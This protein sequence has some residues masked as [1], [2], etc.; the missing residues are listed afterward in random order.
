MSK[1]DNEFG[2]YVH[3]GVGYAGTSKDNARRIHPRV[4]HLGVG[5]GGIYD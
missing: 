3:Y 5:Y 4:A 1:E 2:A